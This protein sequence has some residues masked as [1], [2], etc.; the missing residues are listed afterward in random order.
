MFSVRTL[1]KT[2]LTLVANMCL[3]DLAWSLSFNLEQYMELFWRWELRY[4][5]IDIWMYVSESMEGVV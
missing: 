1:F 2:D 4:Y 5:R 3:I